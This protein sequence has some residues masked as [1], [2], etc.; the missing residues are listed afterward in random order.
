MK[1]FI[2]ISAI[3]LL[4]S[5]GSF[6][7]SKPEEKP[8][9]TP[10]EQPPKEET[11]EEETPEEETQTREEKDK[12]R[13][14]T[15]Y[16]QLKNSFHYTVFTDFKGF[17]GDQPNGIIQSEAFFNFNLRG[18][19]ALGT[20]KPPVELFHNIIMGANFT[21]L[22]DNLRYKKL[23]I[24]ADK[25][26]NTV[27]HAHYIDLVRYQNFEGYI[28]LNLLY[29][30]LDNLKNS[31][32]N[33]PL[34]FYADIFGNITSTGIR[35]TTLQTKDQEFNANS[36]GWGANFKLGTAFIA[37]KEGHLDFEIGYTPYKLYLHNNNFKVSGGPLYSP[38]DNPLNSKYQDEPHLSTIN[39]FDFRIQYAPD[40]DNNEKNIFFR[41]MYHTNP[42]S[43]NLKDDGYKANSFLQVQL[44]YLGTFSSLFPDKKESK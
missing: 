8:K 21:K 10:K 5:A 17:K 6:A 32:I 3:L 41:V 33:I 38:E 1:K 26:D 36:I 34:R 11:P 2:L 44:G 27:K 20:P 13:D 19:H 18:K 12:E 25:N 7:Q 28:K 42:V 15:A 31:F 39:R 4:L 16:S 24:S 43:L 30:R 40:L 23:N 14:K 22:G 37:N 9:E 35:D 29:V